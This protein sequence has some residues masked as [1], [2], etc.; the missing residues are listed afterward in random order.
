MVSAFF[1]NGSKMRNLLIFLFIILLSLYPLYAHYNYLGHEY[2]TNG[3]QY[4]RHQ[5]ML[6]GNSAYFNPW[7]YRV[8]SA[9]LVEFLVQVF[10]FTGTAEPYL[11]A[12]LGFR[13]IEHI[14][15]FIA[16]I[17]FYRHFTKSFYLILLS[18]VVMSYSMS[19]S[20]YDSDLSFNTY[21]DVLFYLTAAIVLFSDLN[22]W[23]FLPVSVLAAFNR[24]TGILIPVIL[25]I[26]SIDFKN[27]KITSGQNLLI[28]ILS[29][30][31]F[32]TIFFSLR[33][34]YGFKVNEVAD[35]LT[36]IKF[37]LTDV[38]TYFYVFGTISILPLLI[39]TGLNKID[40][41]LKIMF[42]FISPV[43]FGVHY[44]MV[45]VEE[46]RLFLVPMVLIF[47][48][49]LINLVD[50]SILEAPSDREQQLKI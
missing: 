5:A 6:Q 34:Y 28:S 18:L 25:M 12:F 35:G 17:I 4:L 38:K 46:S 43:W 9:W 50:R 15:I 20:T 13:F 14:C 10:K 37:N 8:L 48:P 45:P 16:A 49:C 44:L 22:K 36:W 31:A 19:L 26:F 24:E 11:K 29:L 27:R 42:V 23:W 33:I 47:I 41:R 21:L 3:N 39:L 7:Q 1:Y 32:I 40:Y 30:A 2:F